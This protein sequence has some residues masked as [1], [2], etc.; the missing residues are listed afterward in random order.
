[1]GALPSA[2]FIAGNIRVILVKSGGGTDLILVYTG[3]I[4]DLLDMPADP[5]RAHT[6]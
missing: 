6:I 4:S 3:R 2:Y 1:M 5:Q